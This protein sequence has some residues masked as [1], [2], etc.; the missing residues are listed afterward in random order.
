MAERLSVADV[1]LRYPS[2]SAERAKYFSIKED[3]GTRRIR[4]LYNDLNDVFC[5]VVHEFSVNKRT[6]QVQ[7]LN[8]RGDNP[9]Q[10]PLCANG[11]AQKVVLY[12]PILDV[13]TNEILIWTR[14]KSWISQ[15]QGLMM[16]NNPLSGTI[17]EIMRLGR[18]GDMKTQYIPQPIAPNDGTTVQQI[19]Q[20][21]N[22]ELPTPESYMRVMDYAAMQQYALN[23]GSIEGEIPVQRSVPPTAQV[24]QYPNGGYAPT[25]TN[26]QPYGNNYQNVPPVQP[27]TPM[28][29]PQ[30]V[31][32]VP[33]SNQNIGAIP[34][35]RTAPS[36]QN[37]QFSP[38]N[39]EELPF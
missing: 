17:F 36:Q 11:H 24:P 31:A 1:E 35:R 6:Q 39:D 32:P 10:C 16:R 38:I 26:P 25:A 8:A 5:D 34:V 7:C 19:L 13:D 33:T 9:N 27:T 18:P 14:S 28:T 2:Q 37:Q 4:F 21:L 22:A 20:N 30:N 12:I 29:P 15:I 23:I 3:R